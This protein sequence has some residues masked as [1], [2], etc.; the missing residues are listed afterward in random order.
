MLTQS[1]QVRFG[2]GETSS[3]HTRLL[4]CADADNLSVHGV[5][6]RIRLGV[7]ERDPRNQHIAD[8]AFG[9]VFVLGN[10]VGKIRGRDEA[11]MTALL[12]GDTKNITCLPIGR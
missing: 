5:A 3:M 9:Q 10:N 1:P 12:K 11:V 8:G 6:H 4:S 7:L 2:S